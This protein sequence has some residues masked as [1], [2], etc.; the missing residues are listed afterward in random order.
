MCHI[1]C[2]NGSD[3]WWHDPYWTIVVESGLTVCPL[4]GGITWPVGASFCH[5]GSTDRYCSKTG[6]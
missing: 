2:D 1:L 6:V 4:Y 5:G 3:P